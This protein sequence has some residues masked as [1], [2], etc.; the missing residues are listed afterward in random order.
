MA[1][2][3]KSGDRTLAKAVHEKHNS[4]HINIVGGNDT[5]TGS[6]FT[7]VAPDF[8]PQLQTVAAYDDEGGDGGMGKEHPFN[9]ITEA[10]FLASIYGY[11]ARASLGIGWD[12]E[13]VKKLIVT[14]VKDKIFAI[15]VCQDRA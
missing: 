11:A 15:R 4:R 14:K 9:E 5:T 3:Y 12:N 1:F 13:G 7:S 6:D 10:Y 2:C 8:T